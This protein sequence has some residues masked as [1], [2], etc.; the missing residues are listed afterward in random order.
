MKGGG[1]HTG[2]GAG[3][4]GKVK[5]GGRQTGAG[6][7]KYKGA[8]GGAGRNNGGGGG[9]NRGDAQGVAGGAAGISTIVGGGG[10]GRKGSIHF[11]FLSVREKRFLTFKFEENSKR[12]KNSIM[13]EVIPIH[14]SASKGFNNLQNK[15]SW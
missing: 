7:G 13:E 8:G 14:F 11:S 3:A 4:G 6:A 15:I 1:R 10:G 9:N 5:E 12:Q 2:A